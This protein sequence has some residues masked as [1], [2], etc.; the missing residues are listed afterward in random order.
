MG[1]RTNKMLGGTNMLTFK[2]AHE[3]A[4]TYVS[5]LTDGDGSF[6][7]LDSATIIRP[8]GWVFFYQSSLYV[9]TK[10]P[11]AMLAG[12]APFIVNATTGEVIVTGTAQPAEYYLAQYEASLDARTA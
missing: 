5:S 4:V 11:T 3:I 6:A 9:E 10:E 8:Y 2:Q 12:N 1:M 7:I